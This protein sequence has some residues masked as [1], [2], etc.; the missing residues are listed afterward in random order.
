MKIIIN[1]HT[2]PYFNL[3]CEQYMLENSDGEIVMLWRNSPSVIIGKNQNTY[4]ELNIDYVLENKIKV[5]RRLTGGGAVFH[6]LGNINFTFITPEKD[7]K[8]LDFQRFTKPVI[9]TLNELNVPAELS[10]RNDIVVDG[11]KI[12]GNAQTSYNGKIMHHGTLLFSANMSK[13]EGAL[14]PNKEKLSTKGIKSVKSRVGNIT[15]LYEV[16]PEK[17]TESFL[18]RFDGNTVCISESEEKAIQKLADE[19]Y[20]TWEWNF[21]KSGRFETKKEKRFP[22]G[23]VEILL[24]SDKGRIGNIR[25]NG[26]FFG[27]KPISEIENKLIGVQLNMD[28]LIS[29][30]DD[31]GE[32]ISGSDANII[33]ELILF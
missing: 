4:A 10:G 12:S 19:K 27:I 17:F 25:I 9:D 8:A 28:S 1:N 20:M 5:V 16:T 21:G 33:A 13:L 3:A 14:N 26:D 6:D 31:V 24:S 30:L 11:R 23:T 22:F 29:S 32:Y 18:K 7:C 2:D 15:D